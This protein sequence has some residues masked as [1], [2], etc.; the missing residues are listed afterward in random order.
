VV[1]G[2]IQQQ[3]AK[4]G[5]DPLTIDACC[6]TRAEIEACDILVEHYRNKKWLLKDKL[7]KMHRRYTEESLVK[8]GQPIRVAKDVMRVGLVILPDDCEIRAVVSVS[9]Y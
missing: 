3:R 7:H 9:D 6:Q 1:I 4:A 8:V 5:W 2:S